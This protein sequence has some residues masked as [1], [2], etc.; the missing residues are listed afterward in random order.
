[1]NASNS[2]S[3]RWNI[4][5]IKKTSFPVLPGKCLCLSSLGLAMLLD[6]VHCHKG[7]VAV[8]MRPRSSVMVIAAFLD[9]V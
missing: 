3:L 9:E 1:M 5:K 2:T 8:E 4:L 6:Q 7:L